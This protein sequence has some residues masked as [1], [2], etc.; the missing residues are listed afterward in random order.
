MNYRR[1]AQSSTAGFTVLEMLAIA[2]IIG[3][4]AAIAA[5]GW[6]TFMNQRRA[7]AGSDQ[8]A[9][10][11]RKT[12]NEAQRLRRSRGIKFVSAA[13]SATGVPEI[14][15]GSV[16]FQS[17]GT[18]DDV[19]GEAFLLG[20]GKFAPG[21]VEL[22]AF[23]NGD[24]PIEILVFEADGSLSVDLVTAPQPITLRV[25]SPASG[26]SVAKRCVLVETLLGAISS[27]AGDECN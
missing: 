11:F 21:T 18:L 24:N 23:D 16:T 25:A 7:S 22:T 12:Q 2:V 5:P 9:Q 6:I 10:L 27:G 15:I 19:E 4:L 1:I 20:D 13:N 17:N 14:V 3:I 26:S 8:V